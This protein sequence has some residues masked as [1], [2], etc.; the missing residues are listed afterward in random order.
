MPSNIYKQKYI[1]NYTKYML[2]NDE[3]RLHTTITYTF[4]C[5]DSLTTAVEFCILSMYMYEL[6][7]YSLCI[8][9]SHETLAAQ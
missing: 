2:N 1:F 3:I 6:Y 5:V 9:H 8:V 4:A 7:I